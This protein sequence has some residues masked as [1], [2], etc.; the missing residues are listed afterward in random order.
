MAWQFPKRI[1]HPDDMLR[2]GE[3]EYDKFNLY[4]RNKYKIAKKLK[5]KTIVEIGVRAGYS[6]FAFL[7]AAPKAAYRGFDNNRGI[8]GGTKGLKFYAWALQILAEKNVHI[9]NDYNSQEH[10]LL[11]INF[12]PDLMHVDAD[13]SHDGCLNDLNLAK[14]HKAKHILV[15]DIDYIDSVRDAVNLFLNQ[16]PTYGREYHKDCRGQCLITPVYKD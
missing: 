16:N 1:I 13:H 10:A 8:D 4:Y 7:D 3:V 2:F 15:D 12:A 14:A 9:L 6:A 11:P 5:P